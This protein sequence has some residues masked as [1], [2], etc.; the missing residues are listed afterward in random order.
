[1]ISK[2]ELKK[3]L[4]NLGIKVQGNFVNREDVIKMLKTLTRTK[5]KKVRAK[6]ADEFR[7]KTGLD[8]A[9]LDYKEEK[10]VCP[11]CENDVCAC[12]DEAM[13]ATTTEFAK[14]VWVAEDVKSLRPDWSDEECTDFLV[15]EEKY[16]QS[17][18]VEKGWQVIEDLLEQN[19]Y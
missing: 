3:Q 8:E 12:G 16:I 13:A 1:M 10:E 15:E 4:L 11:E 14:V 17:A 2:L 19:H 5:G 9:K 6:W 18:M 7:K